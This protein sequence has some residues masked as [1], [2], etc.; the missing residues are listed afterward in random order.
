[1]KL[2]PLKL[3]KWQEEPTTILTDCLLNRSSRYGSLVKGP[4]GCGKTIVMAEAIARAQKH[5][6][7]LRRD[8]KP[9]MIHPIL[10]LV[11]K[12]S[13]TQTRRVFTRFGLKDVEVLN[14]DSLRSSYGELFIDWVSVMKHGE[15]E[16]EP[17][18]KE[19]FKPELIIVDECHQYKNPASQMTQ[20]I[21]NFIDQGGKVVLISATPFQKASEARLILSATG[22]CPV[23]DFNAYSWEVSPRGPSENSPAAVKRI[24]EDIKNHGALVDIKGVRY[25]FRPVVK[26]YLFT[27][28]AVKLDLIN[29]AYAEYLE[30]LRKHNKHEPSGIRARW[31]A[32]LKF[33]EKCEL[34]RADELAKL[35]D[36][37][38]KNQGRAIIIASNFIPTL[39]KAWSELVKLGRKPEEISFLIGG[40]KE[41]ARQKC[42][43]SFQ[44]GKTN[45][46]L[47]TLKSGGVSLNLNHQF[48]SAKPRTVILPP[49][50]S[51]YEMTQ[52]L[53]RAQ[54]IDNLSQVEQFVCWYAG[55]VE[56][57]VKDR[58]DSKMDC[59]RELYDRKDSFI[60]EVFN[61][62]VD[63]YMAGQFLKEAQSSEDGE[64]GGK[65]EKEE[66]SLFDSSMFDGEQ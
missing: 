17:V 51:V 54:R 57:K 11:P 32:M 23:D 65:T 64:E 36:D 1:M 9:F 61:Q 52:V 28:S 20:V 35:A 50:W 40:Q 13:I 30:E 48:A 8:D 7:F 59:L 56:E 39:R 22:V 44:E 66:E 14:G 21:Q 49:T 2:P 5:G 58:L 31:V 37:I 12:N 41:D 27:P 55:T 4:T 60:H 26:N 19:D 15:L 24:I 18:W 29:Q 46:F 25:P 63:Q 34:L 16:Y 42:I 45:L 53:G 62:E 33:R 3:K 6:Y 38:M 47:T 10:V 43:D